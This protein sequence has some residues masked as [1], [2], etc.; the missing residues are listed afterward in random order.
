MPNNLNI[1]ITGASGFLGKYVVS[2]ALDK[3]HKVL[4]VSRSADKSLWSDHKQ[5]SNLQVVK[6]DLLN[7]NSVVESLQDIDVVIHLAASKTG[8]WQT[9][10]TG[11]VKTTENLLT[12]MAS[13]G[14][15]RLITVSSF[16][17]F[18]Y[19]NIPT[20]ET[21]DE[22]SLL[23]SEPK[24]R[25]AYAQ[26]KLQQEKQFQEFQLQQA[27]EVTV[28][29]PGVIYGKDNLWNARLGINKGNTWVIVNSSA[30]LPL[31]YVENC[32]DAIVLAIESQ[33][34]IN[35]TINLV[36]DDL[37]LQSNYVEKILPYFDNQPKV[38]NISGSMMNA[39]VNL[40]WQTNQKL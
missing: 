24:R 34:S 35:Q 12:A 29:R 2:K 15:K 28:F 38:F 21:I 31:I 37:P 30:L 19:F 9:Q 40:M 17:V 20:G 10:F 26:M 27:G 4:A 39:I 5:K 25:D 14:V 18:D 33:A 6:C 3:G 32:A 16:S 22:N 13:V 8:D 36:D 23:E 1:L 11:T 7:Q